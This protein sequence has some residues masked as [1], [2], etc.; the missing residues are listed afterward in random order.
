MPSKT[1][2][3]TTLASFDFNIGIF[4]Y[5][6]VAPDAAGDLFGTTYLGGADNMGTVYEIAAGSSTVTALANFDGGNGA[7]PYASLATDQSGDLFGTTLAGGADNLG[8]VFEISA[9]S[10]QITALASFA[11][12]NGADPEASVTFDAS[13]DLFGTTDMGGASDDGTVFEIA[14]G[15]DQIA[16][17]A[18]FAGADGANPQGPVVLD[19]HGDLFGTTN[20]GGANGE[21]TV[22]EIAAGSSAI[23]TIASFGGGSG[24]NPF[25]SVTLDALGDIFG[26]TIQGGAFQ[27]GTIFEIVAGSNRITTLASF[28]GV[29]GSYPLGPVT[30][31]AAGDLFG[32]ATAGGAAGT[33]TIYELAAGSSAIATLAS[34][35]GDSGAYAQTALTPDMAGDLFGTAKGGGANNLGAVFELTNSGFVPPATPAAPI[36]AQENANG[37]SPA[38]LLTIAGTAA[39]GGLVTLYD[40][41]VVIGTTAADLLTG[42]YSF[43]LSQPFADGSHSFTV[44]A[45]VSGLTSPFSPATGVIVDSHIPLATIALVDDTSGGDLITY[46]DALTGTADRNATIQLSI[47]GGP[48][49]NVT[50]NAQGVWTY[51]PPSLSTG[52]HAVTIVDADPAGISTSASI[53]FRY[54]PHTPDA[55]AITRIFGVIATTIS[56]NA[57]VAVVPGAAVSVAG[58]MDEQD[59]T[60]E[61]F[62]GGTEIGSGTVQG[63]GA[64]AFAVAA[65]LSGSETLTTEFVDAAGKS[66]APSNAVTLV[67]DPG[68]SVIAGAIDLTAGKAVDLTGYLESLIVPGLPGDRETISSNSADLVQNGQGEWIYTTPATGLFDT[69]SFT[70]TDQYGDTATGSVGV[71]I[72]H[73]RTVVYLQGYDNSVSAPS[74]L[75]PSSGVAG[76]NLYGPQGGFWNVT[77]SANDIVITAYGYDNTINAG[78]GNDTIYAGLSNASVTV[79]DFNG[80]NTVIGDMPGDEGTS[81]I[82]LG[83]GNNTVTLS[84]YDNRIALG[85]GDNTVSAGLGGEIVRVGNGDNTVETDGSGNTILVGDGRNTIVAGNGGDSVTVAGGTANIA[86]TGY[87]DDFVLNGGN[88]TISGP[89]GLATIT[90]GAGFGAGSSVDLAG[91]TGNL[92]EVGG[93]WEVLE[94]D[95]QVFATFATPSGESLHSLSD[96][97]G[98]M[99]IETGAATSPPPPATVTET[100]G[101]QTITLVPP[102]TTLNLWGYDNHV[103]SLYGGFAIQG[104]DGF[105]TFDLAGDGNTLVLGGTGD[106]IDIGVDNQGKS[107]A[108]GDNTISGTVGSTT[109]V[110]GNGNQ[111][112]ALGGYYNNIVT[113]V[114]DSAIDAG[115]GYDSVTVAGGD[116]SITV[117]GNGNTIK[118]GSGDDTVSLGTGWTN[119]VHGGSGV[120]TI[121]GGYGNTYIAGTGTLN[122]TDFNAAYGDVLD[123]TALEATLGVTSSAFTLANTASGLSVYVTGPHSATTLVATL[124]DTHGTLAG[125]LAAH[126]IVA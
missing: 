79:S 54:D 84:G 4:P 29:D 50:A 101:G 99:L 115:V 120:A 65:P 91:F 114:G 102:T 73:A 62:S 104:D 103:S 71:T 23:T 105:S 12:S 57:T 43:A 39:D 72:G 42:A 108:T 14:A 87:Y 76:P 118:L 44:T 116:N 25:A 88:T 9:G 47:D 34:L 10:D 97:S 85:N 51:T 20:A 67:A 1:P 119:I 6:G 15:S 40:N 32:A 41:G 48:A 70:V 106:V 3:L 22:F 77:G 69:I 49:V 64:F 7:Y 110:V 81:T 11:G 21:G 28:D 38:G 90:L 56:G 112:I 33:G 16:T 126:T 37:Y 113:G 35:A 31:D 68:P 83:D 13:G 124:A 18:S 89:A 60:I 27:D 74:S 52:P 93:V 82:A 95:T 8:T 75:A 17:L 80:D 30:L 125:L 122:V 111:T 46:D 55:P 98:G 123:L 53:S 5:S 59:G 2:S 26:T 45:T 117:T 94:P 58:T 78:G 107:I 19:S 24:A 63:N 100:Q 121:G 66:S 96:G 86:V 61:L 109:V 92:V 36:V